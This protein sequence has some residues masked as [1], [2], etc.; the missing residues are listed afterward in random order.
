ML[1]RNQLSPDHSVSSFQNQTRLC[2]PSSPISSFTVFRF[3]AM[4]HLYSSDSDNSD[5]NRTATPGANRA[6][7]AGPVRPASHR[8]R[9]A[10]A[11]YTPPLRGSVAAAAAAAAAANVARAPATSGGPT[12]PAILPAVQAA[13]GVDLNF[14]RP[15]VSPA[16]PGG[17]QSWPQSVRRMTHFDE[18]VNDEYL[19]EI[20]QFFQLSGGY[21]EVGEQLAYVPQPRQYVVTIYIIL[22]MREEIDRLRQQVAVPRGVAAAEAPAADQARNWHYVP[23]FTSFVQRRAHELL[24]SR[25]LRV[26]GSDTPRGAPQQVRS[27]LTLVLDH[28]NAQNN[29]FKRDY[30]PRGYLD[31]DPAAVSSLESFVRRKLRHCRCRLRDLLLCAIQPGPGRGDVTHPVPSVSSL[32]ADMRTSLIPPNANHPEA[33]GG[34]D[35]ANQSHLKARIAYLRIHTITQYVGRGPG[36]AGRQWK[37]I[38]MHLLE[39]QGKGRLYRTAFYQLVLSYDHA[40]FGQQFFT[41]MDPDSIRLPTEQEVEERMLANAADDAPVEQEAGLDG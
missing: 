9:V 4:S 20:E 5:D 24:L 21:A 30:L 34:D 1:H 38:D 31:G 14:R 39:L 11:T 33:A 32:I 10:A 17:Q 7:N 37:N 12:R 16:V 6:S 36:D 35:R 8:R 28:I 27:L 19:G 13:A 26:Y 29:Q 40:T 2:L 3:S 41:E 15:T 25:N 18:P 23:V 22:A